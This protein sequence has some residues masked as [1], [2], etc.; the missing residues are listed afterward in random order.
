MSLPPELEGLNRTA[1]IR[2]SDGPWIC[3]AVIALLRKSVNDGIRVEIRDR[4]DE[5]NWLNDLQ[6]TIGELVAIHR[7]ES[8]VGNN[9]RVKHDLLSFEGPVDDVDLKIFGV[10][11]ESKCHAWKENKRFF[12]V[13]KEAHGKSVTRKAIG[14]VP[15]LTAECAKIALVGKFVPIADLDSWK[16]ENF[17][18]GDPALVKP[19]DEFC[20]LYLRRPLEV[21]RG[22]LTSVMPN[23]GCGDLR[24]RVAQAVDRELENLKRIFSNPDRFSNVRELTTVVWNTIQRRT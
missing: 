19:L 3:A 8:I 15:V 22:E 7:V 9:D 1:R 17:G 23:A 24:E 14:Y 5:K 16:T 11:I 2:L 21:V 12:A 18:Y 10:G 6:G 20:K 13:N 4:G